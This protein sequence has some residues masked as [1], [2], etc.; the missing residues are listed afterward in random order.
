[1]DQLNAMRAFVAVAETGHFA[2][3][4]ERLGLSRAMASRLVM[5]LEARLGVRLL[6][7]TTRRVGLTGPGAAY[8]DRCREILAA[9]EEAESEIS[10]A[11]SEPIGRLRVTAPVSF[12]VSHVAPRIAAFAA[13]HP[14]VS[15]DLSLN[16]RL[17][18]IVE[19]G[20]DLAIRIGRLSDSSL[21]ARRIGE[22]RMVVCAA[23][24]Y[25]AARG[26]P[27]TPPELTR[28]DCLLYSYASAGDVWTFEGP[29]GAES[30]RVSGRVLC[31]NGDAMCRMA[32]EGLGLVAQPDFIAAPHLR[33]GTLEQ[34]L[35]GHPCPATGVYAVQA[36]ARHAP[37]KLRLF[38][39]FLAAALSFSRARGRN[40]CRGCRG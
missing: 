1:M 30:V 14:R 17:V 11:A 15:V 40:E 26:R 19:E 5:D 20:Y 18:D 16:D 13:R 35:S 2:T 6:N 21:I 8:L 32:A 23:P 27:A 24:A 39:D 3:A 9:L 4:S 12:G 29:R 38:V 28:H 37:L 34:V 31:N 10:S 36:S 7:R 33:A 25:L 22:T